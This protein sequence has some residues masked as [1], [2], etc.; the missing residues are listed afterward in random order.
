[1]ESCKI[2]YGRRKRVP[3]TLAWGL[4]ALSAGPGTIIVICTGVSAKVKG[5]VSVGPVGGAPDD[6]G[7]IGLRSIGP[8]RGTAGDNRSEGEAKS[9]E[10]KAASKRSGSGHG[11]VFLDR[12]SPVTPHITTIGRIMVLDRTF[13]CR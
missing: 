3:T 7:R 1:M 10:A 6:V 5:L 4:R 12:I 11:R 2:A 9:D 13:R 8:I